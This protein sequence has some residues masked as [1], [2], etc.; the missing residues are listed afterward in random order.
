[1]GMPFGS[2]RSAVFLFV[3]VAE[4]VLG[5][6]IVLGEMGESG[7]SPGS[8]GCGNMVVVEAAVGGV[9][10]KAITEAESAW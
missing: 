5:L 1:M 2:F 9:V 10:R 7:S 3:A 4:R 8:R 6:G